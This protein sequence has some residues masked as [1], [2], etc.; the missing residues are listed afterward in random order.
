M[1]RRLHAGLPHAWWNEAAEG[2][3]QIAPSAPAGSLPETLYVFSPQGQLFRFHRGCTVVDYAYNV[4]TDLAD[5]CEA[6]YVNDELVELNTPLHHLDLVRR[7]T[8]PTHP[9]RRKFG[10]TPRIPAVSARASSASRAGAAAA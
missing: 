4:H 1:R 5:Q 8:T 9:A 3:A 10:S 6:F 2:R 7:S